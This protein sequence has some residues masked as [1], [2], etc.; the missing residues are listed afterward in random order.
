V[1]Y[2]HSSAITSI[3]VTESF[4]F[5]GGADGKINKWETKSGE[6]LGTFTG[7]DQ[8][9]SMLADKNVIYS[10]SADQTIRGKLVGFFI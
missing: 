1:T 10:G 2:I 3:C 9:T 6:L 8:V 7:H 5:T 4:V